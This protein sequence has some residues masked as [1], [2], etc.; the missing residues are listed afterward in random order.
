MPRSDLDWA[1]KQFVGNP[2]MKSYKLRNNYYNGD[3]RLTFA[4]EKFR[5]V[6][7]LL[8]MEL[9]DNLCPAVVDAVADRMRITNFQSSLAKVDFVEVEI[10]PE[11]QPTP[12]PQPDG[13][14]IPPPQKR[15]KPVTDD[16]VG[17]SAWEFWEQDDMDLTADEVHTEMLKAGDAYAIVWFDQKMNVRV[18]PQMAH[19]MAVKYNK[20]DP[21]L[22]DRACKFWKDEDTQK[23]RINLYYPNVIEKYISTKVIKGDCTWGL[24]DVASIKAEDFTVYDSPVPNRFNRVPVF[25]FQN[26]VQSRKGSSELDDVIPVQD[27]LNKS[28]CDMLISMEFNSFRQRWATGIEVE[29]DE[30]TGRPKEPP[31]NYGADRMI[32]SADPDVKFGEFAQSD[33]QQF[34]YVQDSLRAEIAR[35]S[36]TPLHYFF[37]T[38]ADYPSGEALKSSEVRFTKKVHDRLTSTGA[39]WEDVITFALT[40]QGN[41]PPEDTDIDPLWANETSRSDS[42][43]MDV[44]LKKKALGVSLSQLLR[45]AGYD[46]DQIATIIEEQAA[47]Q[48][49]MPQKVNVNPISNPQGSGSPAGL[50][51]ASGRTSETPAGQGQLTRSQS[52]QAPLSGGND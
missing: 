30:A 50:T 4:S 49:V 17:K 16:P 34:V 9:A 41:P 10:P 32:A 40:L 22:I 3:H 5:T 37:I 14:V 36:G 45:E 26:K 11:A 48:P 44:L 8:F 47:N 2:R 39:A 42:E 28:M 33:L 25:H 46:E 6:F 1:L 31:F 23:I 29:V 51:P 20:D 19:E 7:G 24:G 13:T 38:K 35:V 52:G 27:A 21:C 43:I 12:G 18:Y 15:V